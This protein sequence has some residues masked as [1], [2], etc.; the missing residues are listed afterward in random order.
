LRNS[1]ALRRRLLMHC[2]GMPAK[3]AT[4]LQSPLSGFAS[5]HRSRV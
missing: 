5:R 2:C 4:S 1:R 3:L